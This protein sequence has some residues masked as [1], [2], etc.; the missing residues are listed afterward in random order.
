VGSRKFLSDGEKTICDRVSHAHYH[1]F[2]VKF[3][4]RRNYRGR[5]T[6]DLQMSIVLPHVRPEY[7]LPKRVGIRLFNWVAWYA[8]AMYDSLA[9]DVGSNYQEGVSAITILAI[10]FSF[11]VPIF[12][13]CFAPFTLWQVAL[14]A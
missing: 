6:G 2:I 8:P 14:Y 9:D 5:T 3:A 1:V 11:I 12:L 4:Y 7:P 13:V 10:V